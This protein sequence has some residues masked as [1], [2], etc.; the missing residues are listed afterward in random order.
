MSSPVWNI[1]TKLFA[2]TWA[3]SA[4]KGDLHRLSMQTNTTHHVLNHRA[5]LQFMDSSS[6]SPPSFTA[7]ILTGWSRFDHFMPLCDLLPTAYESLIS[8][9]HMINT[10]QMID[11]ELTNDCE[12]LLNSI[13]KDSQLCQLLPGQYSM[14]II[15]DLV[16]FP[17]VIGSFHCFHR[18]S[19]LVEHIIIIDCT[20][21]N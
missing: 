17:I 18:R 9:L 11:N 10:G 4:F 6:V 19:Y 20:H 12:S 15:I 2:H 3:A 21:T 1:Y 14:N 8:S 7:L 5:W 16:H 13:G